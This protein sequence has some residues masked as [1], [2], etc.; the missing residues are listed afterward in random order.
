MPSVGMLNAVFAK[1]VTCIN[2]KLCS[3]SGNM[4]PENTLVSF[5]FF[6]LLVCDDSWVHLVRR[7]LFGLFYQLRIIMMMVDVEQLV[8]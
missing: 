4:R 3:M 7:P 1:R 2:A 8:E 5:P 6:L